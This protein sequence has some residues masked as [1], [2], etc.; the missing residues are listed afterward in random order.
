MQDH[1]NMVSRKAEPDSRFR[2]KQNRIPGFTDK[3]LALI[4]KD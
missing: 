4:E 3:P 2:E 1:N